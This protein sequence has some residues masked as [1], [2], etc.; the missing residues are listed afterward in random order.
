MAGD[1]GEQVGPDESSEAVTHDRQGSEVDVPRVATTRWQVVS[2]EAVRV[3]PRFWVAAWIILFA[4]GNWPWGLALLFLTGPV[5]ALVRGPRGSV[6]R[7]MQKDR[8]RAERRA[9]YDRRVVERD[10]RRQGHEVV[11]SRP[12]PPEERIQTYGPPPA[13]QTSRTSTP[14]GWAWG[15]TAWTAPEG[16]QGSPAAGAAPVVPDAAAPEK[17]LTAAV[18]AARTGP[19]AVDPD[20]L[21]LVDELDSALRPMLVRARQG[22]IDVLVRRDLESIALEHLPQALRA[23]QQLPPG[24]AHEHR[25]VDGRTPAEELRSQLG[26]LVEGCAPLRDAVHG[27]D[28]ARQRELGRFLEAKFRRSDLDL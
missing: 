2:S 8:H 9:L 4:T 3:F 12:V 20:A 21:A 6:R 22:G 11:R 18:A 13:D 23:Y 7:Q 26:L 14:D 17:A 19:A 10:L 25:G 5:M 24:Y 15:W 16:T 27:A 28:V 1:Q